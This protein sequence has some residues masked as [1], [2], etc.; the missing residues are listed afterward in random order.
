M[1]LRAPKG[2]ID[3]SDP[4]VCQIGHPAPPWLIN[5]AD[6]MTEMVC[7][8]I[9]LYALSAALNKDVG[10]GKEQLDK[11][12]REGKVAG[13]VKIEREGM[14]ISIQEKGDMAF[15]E[16]GKADI[17]PGMISVLEKIS[18]TI[19]DLSRQFDI[20]VEGHTDAIPINDEYFGSN[21]E[22]SS[23]RATTV[24]EY[25]VKEKGFDPSHL[26]AMGYGQFQPV[27]ANDSP[28]NRAKNRRV[29]FFVKTMK[30]HAPP[31]PGMALPSAPAQ[32]EAAPAQ[33]AAA[34]KA[35]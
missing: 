29:V 30:P 1:P 9:I 15:F 24:V 14:K 16:S 28:E 22:L 31:P 32:P 33:G 8:F 19:K 17:T 25:L 34:A 3:E 6:L 35:P 23:A 26:A 5:Y 11:L 27:A 10:K 21:W 2:F 20:V 13:E 4:K 12:M 7:F 18:P